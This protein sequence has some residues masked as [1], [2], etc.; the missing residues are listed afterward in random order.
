[1]RMRTFISLATI[2]LRVKKCANDF[3]EKKRTKNEIIKMNNSAR[4]IQNAFL[5]RMYTVASNS[6]KRKKLPPYADNNELYVRSRIEKREILKA[7]IYVKNLVNMRTVYDSVQFFSM[8]NSSFSQIQ[9]M[10]AKKLI[11]NF[12]AKSLLTYE[13]TKRTR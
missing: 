3:M 13:F 2:F 1:M 5:R 10:R 8:Y 7:R 11:C 4:K 6:I 12:T 9:R